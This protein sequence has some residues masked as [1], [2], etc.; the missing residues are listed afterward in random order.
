MVAPKIRFLTKI[1]HPN[2][3]KLGRICMDTLKGSP[4][5]HSNQ[6]SNFNQETGLQ[7]CRLELSF[8]RS[9]HCLVHPIQTVLSPPRNTNPDPLAADVAQQWKENEANAIATGISVYPEG[10]LIVA[11]EWTRLY[12]KQV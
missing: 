7:L 11:R 12:A 6:G 1:Y 9:K 2:I 5:R 10:R 3:D 4:A 8:Y